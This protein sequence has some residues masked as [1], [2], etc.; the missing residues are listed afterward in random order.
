MRPADD[1]SNK[2]RKML[3]NVN[4]LEFGDDFQ[5]HH[6][7]CIEISTN[8]LGIGSVIPEIAF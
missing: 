3:K 8:M 7:K 2:I 1:T 5:T 6:K 4:I